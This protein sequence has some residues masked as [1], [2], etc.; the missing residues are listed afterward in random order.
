M[1]IVGASLLA[2]LDGTMACPSTSLVTLILSNGQ[3]GLYPAP[4]T[5]RHRCS[6]AGAERCLSGRRTG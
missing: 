6:P 2:M 1:Q 3:A 4:I 5:W